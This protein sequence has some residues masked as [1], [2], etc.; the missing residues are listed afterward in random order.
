MFINDFKNYGLRSLINRHLT[1]GDEI[2]TL[3]LFPTNNYRVF[4]EFEVLH[5]H[6]IGKFSSKNINIS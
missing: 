1:N 2:T 6:L 4:C 3:K 5:S